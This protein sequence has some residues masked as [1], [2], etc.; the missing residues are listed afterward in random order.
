MLKEVSSS[1]SILEFC[2]ACNRVFIDTPTACPH[3]GRFVELAKICIGRI[4]RWVSGWEPSRGCFRIG[5][6]R[7]LAHR[8]RE[9]NA[10]A[11]NS[12]RHDFPGPSSA[13]LLPKPGAAHGD[14]P[15]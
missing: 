11:I 9:C 7:R 4:R 14:D 10:Y 6:C 12:R 8:Y 13:D 3:A 1:S 15:L 5:E 2:I